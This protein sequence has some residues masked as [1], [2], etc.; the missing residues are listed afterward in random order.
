MDTPTVRGFD[1]AFVPTAKPRLLSA[2]LPRV[3]VKVVETVDAA[4]LS[5]AWTNASKARIHSGKSPVVVLLF[6]RHIAAQAELLRALQNF[7]RQPK[8]PDRPHE[9]AIVAVDASN[10]NCRVPPGVSAP[11]RTLIEHI[12]K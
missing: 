11:V 2:P 7:E 12:C 8:A 1:I 4:V 6:G 3:L 10:W 9:I 5:D